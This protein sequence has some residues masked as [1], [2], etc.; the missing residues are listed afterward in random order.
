MSKINDFNR[1]PYYNDFDKKK[2]YMNIMY[3]P[4]Y[5]VQ[6][7]E[8]NQ[9]QSITQNQIST[10]ADHVFKNGSKVSN[11]R[12][13]IVTRN[14]A[15][16]LDVYA[17]T[18]DIVDVEQFDTSYT[19]IGEVSKVEGRYIKGS[20]KTID[21]DPATLFLIYTK[22]GVYQ[23]NDI[24]TFVP[25]ETVAV[26]DKN[27][28]VVK[29]VIVRCPG[30]P[31][32]D[33]PEEIAPIGNAS[34]FAIDEGV[35]YFNSY[36]IEVAQQEI[37]LIK[38]IEYN[39]SSMVINKDKFKIGLDLI[40][41]IL[42]AEDSADLFDPSLG[43]PNYAAPG[44]DR[45]QV[46]LRL[47]KRSYAD[48]DGDNFVLLAKVLEGLQVE[49][50]KSDAEYSQL[51]EEFARRT[52]E[53][54]GNFTVTP[55][56]TKF[57]EAQKTATNGAQ[58]WS[59][60]GKEKDLVAVISPALSYV[61]GFRQ[62]TKS[63]TVVTFEKARDTEKAD[64]FTQYFA[65]RPY[66]IVKPVSNSHIVSPNNT[67]NILSTSELELYDGPIV[68]GQ[69]TG[70]NI[71]F[72]KVID[73]S[74][75]TDG[76]Y[77]LY[78]YDVTITGQGANF[79]QVKSC[80]T[81]NSQFVAEMNRQDGK[82]TLFDANNITLIYPIAKEFIRSL[83]DIQN[84]D[85]GDTTIFIRRKLVGR[86]DNNGSV[87]FTA[88]TNESFLVFNPQDN[89]A[90]VGTAAKPS[91]MVQLTASNY[92][93]T[94]GSLTVQAGPGN[95]NTEIVVYSNI[96]KVSQLEN[97]KIIDLKTFT[98]ETE[99][100]GV[101]GEV[102]KLKVADA[103]AIKSIQLIGPQGDTVGDVTDQ[104]VLQDG[105]TDMYYTESSIKRIATSSISPGSKLLI[106]FYYFKHEGTA[107][108][109][110]VDSYSQIL[111]EDN[112]WKLS[113]KDIPTFMSS[114]G[115]AYRLA[116]SFDFRP[117]LMDGKMS[118][119][120]AIPVQ[121]TTTVFD[122]EF[123][124]PRIDMLCINAGGDIHVKKGT[125]SLNPVPPK[126]EPEVMALYEIR[127]KAYTF[128][129]KGVTTKFI[130]NR[131]YTMS[132]IGKIEK[133]VEKLEYYQ[134]LSQLESST[135]NMSVKDQNG[136]DR[137]KNGM[138]VDSFAN[139]DGGD[140]LNP[141]FKSTIDSQR[142]E[143]R[144]IAVS[145]STKLEV[146]HAASVNVEQ[147]GNM[148]LIPYDEEKFQENAFATKSLSINPYMSYNKKGSIALSPN[149]DTWSDTDRLP[150]AILDIDTGL[151]AISQMAEASGMLG[152]KYG[153]WSDLNTTTQMT[154]NTSST[155]K[156]NTGGKNEW[157]L[158]DNGWR[159]GV[160]QV[161]TVS[162]FQTGTS[163]SSQTRQVDTVTLESRKNE[164]K[165]SD[166][167]KD[168]SIQPY[169][170]S[171]VVEFYGS[172]L[173]ANRTVYVFFDG[174]NVTK[175][176]RLIEAIVYDNMEI[177]KIRNQ[178]I[179]GGIPLKTD[180]NGEIRGEFRIPPETFFTG[181]KTFVIT[182]DPKNTGN[183][184]N[185]TTSASTVYF[186][187]GITQSK[188][189]ST[190]N[191]ITPSFKT[192]SRTEEK[193]INQTI[194]SRETTTTEVIKDLSSGEII[195]NNTTV[196]NGA[197]PSKVVNQWSTWW[198]TDPVAQSFTTIEPCFITRI[199][200]YFK[201]VDVTSDIIWVELRTMENGYPTT[202]ALTRKEYKPEIINGFVSEDSTKPFP[203]IFDM[204]VFVS[205][206]VSYCFV[207]GGYS[208]DTRLWVSRLGEEVVN[209][210]GKIV[211]E[212]PT[213]FSS[214]R[215]LNGETWNAEQFENIKHGLYRAVF[216]SRKMELKLRNVIDQTPLQLL[217]NPFEI[218]QGSNRVRVHA[219]NHGVNVLDRVSTSLFDGIEI[220][221]EVGNTVP[222]QITQ[223]LT[224]PTGSGIVTDITLGDTA[225]TYKVKLKN[226]QGIFVVGQ[227]FSGESKSRPFRDANLMKENGNIIPNSIL[228]NESNG[229]VRSDPSAV[230]GYDK[231][232]GATLDLFNYEHVVVDVDSID[233][234]IVEI[235]FPFTT[236]GRFGGEY[237]SAFDISRRYEL[238]NITGAYLPYGAT[239]RTTLS[240]IKQTQL[241]EI[242]KPLEFR[243]N[244][245]NYLPY[246]MKMLSNKNE[247]RVFGSSG[248]RSID[249]TFTFE[250]PSSYLSPVI[251]TDSFSVI[252]VSNRVGSKDVT[253][254]NVIPNG[255][256][257]F[258]PETENG[259]NAFK[260]VTKK[261]LLKDPAAELK[262]YVDV[263]KEVNADFDIY[264][265]PIEVHETNSEENIEWMIVDTINKTISS[266]GVN[267][268][269][270][271]EISC[272]EEC[273]KWRDGLEFIGYR[274]KIVGYADNPAKH[275][276][277]KTF[278][279]IAVT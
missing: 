2:N 8:L 156:T 180:E 195:E 152:A 274:V 211:E 190:M 272:S 21:G 167:V 81:N 142:G 243:I 106:S 186:A 67:P 53:Q 181:E 12:T 73:Q 219:P 191:V 77:R 242:E 187:G 233:S 173:K 257:R 174:I 139:Y 231:I 265:K 217:K 172:R 263:Y 207:V 38:Y 13:S 17:D 244:T 51:G 46:E 37:T 218:Q 109:F 228:I 90:Y 247:V 124:L 260:Y 82:A 245:D 144:P 198:N 4:G 72:V 96:Q 113:Y 241:H 253:K 183:D 25:G 78:V 250:S 179:Y 258:I 105:Q 112:E 135:V 204:P 63:D 10:F 276:M 80:K 166:I 153:S 226:I 36:F 151:D 206:N 134:A 238:Y 182:D 127:L 154:D 68:A 251:N 252:T 125:A 43:Y 184:D 11:C 1:S 214:F 202:T 88:Q 197:P 266:N 212:P 101:I 234:F 259:S 210:P 176:C 223:K 141:E 103:F 264:V 26:V 126:I 149:I 189:D 3:K 44:A 236:T 138:L 162:T 168:V 79:G 47:V 61:K 57:Y 92:V 175:Y 248:R 22:A 85:N 237:G 122:V 254:Y 42:T 20:N 89:Y 136:F 16:L 216:K 86:T 69:P 100:S 54:A 62:E 143:L 199:D 15:R 262:V 205:G 33:L 31:N 140:L 270:E 91:G 132:D 111:D 118:S 102:F 225:N 14:Y 66:I 24:A 117:I 269:I 170:R 9:A 158:S 224:T 34:M 18:N 157:M 227:Q 185:S 130:D 39:E 169:I 119:V 74:R 229:F 107:G 23:D 5:A 148:A 114:N 32:S 249:A 108:Y 277:F 121:S 203:V 56:K 27:G 41:M 70:N 208:P 83:R 131:R 255:E 155:T 261:V 220:L 246:S 45:Y 129:I 240:P 93:S 171:R 40:E 110:T 200:L 160:P 52:F 146:D 49:Y 6:G 50:M 55:Y 29:R 178:T 159:W 7:R 239:E 116:D 230:I 97:T 188:Q 104:F 268:Y 87:T 95:A 71:G 275:P 221:L 30:C 99:P 165:I 201:E 279:T 94:G 161:T 196:V 213:P 209:I 177:E 28:V 137:Y 128:D 64:N 150:D 115:V 120:T 60:T 147:K 194:T 192:Q 123:Y 35:I 273:S 19:L 267:D 163:N 278:R 256:N 271:Y 98:H 65:N 133:R 193:T 48:E 164:Y 232:G 58:G 235:A 76:N 145:N 215:S 222:P 84:K 75:L 59:L